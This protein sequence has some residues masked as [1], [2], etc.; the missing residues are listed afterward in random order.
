MNKQS[1]VKEWISQTKHS[2]KASNLFY[3]G[4]TIYS[5]GHH[6]PLGRIVGGKNSKEAIVNTKKVNSSTS[7]QLTAVMKDLRANGFV[8]FDMRSG[9]RIL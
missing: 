1:L 2:N 5:Y 8:M 4:R 3:E 7:R 9:D 6:H